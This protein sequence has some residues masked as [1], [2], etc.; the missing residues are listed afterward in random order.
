MLPPELFALDSSAY[1]FSIISRDKDWKKA[2]VSRDFGGT[3]YTVQALIPQRREVNSTGTVMADVKSAQLRESLA[4]ERDR[5]RWLRCSE[6]AVRCCQRMLELPPSPAGSNM[7]PR[8]WDQLQCWGDTPAAST[9][10]EDCPSYLFSEDTCGASGKKAQK[11]CLADGRW[12]RHISNN[13]W[14]NYTDC[15]YKKIV[16]ENIKLR[17]RWH[18]AVCSLSVAALLPALIIFFSY[19]Q[20]QVRR[21]TL[22]KHLFLSLILEAIFNICLR[23][24]QISSPSVISMSPWWCVVLNTVLRYLRQSNYTWFF[25]EGFYLHRLLA[26][27]FAEQRNFLI[28]YCLGW[29]LPVLPVTVYVV[30][31][32]AVYKSV[33]G[34]LILPQEGIEWILMIL[35]FTAIIINVIFFI[36]IIRILVLKLRA[37]SDSRNGNDIRQYK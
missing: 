33:T 21:I 26:S 23:S 9:A 22:H 14:T 36:N 25:N 5:D 30:V 12:F 35:P 19:R 24:L 13:E 10:Y 11:E 17:M 16:A 32:A 37:T 6:A 27:A 28:F 20:L 34:C 7:C 29:G 3:T 1:C 18:I 8:T 15:D 4:T 2:A 31:R